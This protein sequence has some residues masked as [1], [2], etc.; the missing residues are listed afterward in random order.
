MEAK[1]RGIMIIVILEGEVL[2]NEREEG[3]GFL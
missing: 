1:R 2:R 3:K